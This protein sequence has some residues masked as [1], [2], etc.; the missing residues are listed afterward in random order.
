MSALATQVQAENLQRVKNRIGPAVE[1]FWRRHA[2]NEETFHAADLLAYVN[3]LI[4]GVAPDSPLRVLRSYRLEGRVN[5]CVVDRAQSLYRALPLGESGLASNFW[6]KVEKSDGCWLWRGAV[7]RGGLGYGRFSLPN[8]ESSTAH[9]VAWE[10]VNGPIPDGL[11][12]RHVV[13]R[14]PLCVRPEHLALGTHRDNMNDRE[15]DGMTASG[16]RHG[17][18]THPERVPRGERAAHAKLT[19]DEVVRLIDG[20]VE[21]GKTT[22]QLAAE[23]GISRPAVRAIIEGR[24]WAHVSNA[25]VAELREEVARLREL[26]EAAGVV[27]PEAQE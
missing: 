25:I 17:S 15:R 18:R 13:C 19:T 26:L 12:V 24:N 9:R 14:N 6:A 11:I 21:A 22:T 4:P 3:G 27:D 7:V 1:L 23:F 8:Q 16:E 20:S 2:A 10:F 5:F